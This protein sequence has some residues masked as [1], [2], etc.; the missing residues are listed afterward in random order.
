VLVAVGLGVGEVNRGSVGLVVGVGELIVGVS[1]AW[2]MGV[3]D[4][5]LVAKGS[6]Y[7]E[8]GVV[9]TVGTATSLEGCG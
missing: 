7:G 5:V 1:V 2:G 8:I 3:T 6:G 4:W 9:P